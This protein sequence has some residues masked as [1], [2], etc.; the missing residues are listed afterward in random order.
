MIRLVFT[1]IVSDQSYMNV[2]RSSLTEAINII[3]N[4]SGLKYKLE[5]HQL[6]AKELALLLVNGEK[7]LIFT[8]FPFVYCTLYGVYMYYILV[9]IK[10]VLT[11]RI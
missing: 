9:F 5:F 10:R 6:A 1:G 11:L 7:N 8:S 2:S 3:N 4:H